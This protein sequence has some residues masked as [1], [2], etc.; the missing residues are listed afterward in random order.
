M[1]INDLEDE[2]R[3]DSSK[4]IGYIKVV[5]GIS[6]LVLMFDNWKSI[7]AG[8]WS[9]WIVPRKKNVQME[10]LVEFTM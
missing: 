3:L 5:I 4:E 2:L 8:Y 6:D 7:G 10:D 1:V 9:I